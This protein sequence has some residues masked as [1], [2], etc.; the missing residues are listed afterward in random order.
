MLLRQ[1]EFDL[2]CQVTHRLDLSI[3]QD[4]QSKVPHQGWKSQHHPVLRTNNEADDEVKF[5]F[6]AGLQGV[7]K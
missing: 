5:D 6:N 4:C 2:S 1:R 7:I 3:I